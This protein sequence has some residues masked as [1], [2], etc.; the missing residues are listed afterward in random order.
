MKK[1][2]FLLLLVSGPW[3]MA[4]RYSI[5]GQVIDS[6]NGAMPSATILLQNAQD[7]TLANFAISNAQGQFEIKNVGKG[8]F[9]LKITF[10]G[11]KSETRKVVAPTEGNVLDFG[12]V[13][14]SPQSK[15]LSEV[16]VAGERIPI[17]VKKDTIEY[18]AAAFKTQANAVVE[19]MLKKMP[20]IEVET[21]GTITA[22]GEEVQR[23][24]VDGKEFFGRD[25]KLATQ[26][27]PADAVD[28]VQ[29]FDR[30]SEQAQFSGIDDGQREKTINLELKEDRKNGAFGNTSVGGGT[31]ERWQAKTN[32]NRFSPNSRL[33]FLGMANNVNQQGF[34]IDEYMNFT[35]G[36]Q[37]M[38]R[39]A[40]GGG[41]SVRMEFSSNNSTG[42]PLSFGG[43]NN[44]LMT[45]YAAGLNLN[46]N[47]G[48]KTELNSSYFFN[49]LDH[50]ITQSLIRENYL[51]NDLTLNYN[52]NSTQANTNLNHRANLTL[53]QEIDSA[54]SLRL[55]ANAS[56][57]QTQSLQ[58]TQSEN[59]SPN[60]TPLNDNTQTTYSE[61]G[62]YNWNSSL[63]YRHK[64]K[65]K[66]RTLSINADLDLSDNDRDGTL[67]GT[68]NNYGETT[69]TTITNQQNEQKTATQTY[70]GS[71]SFTE[72]LGGRKYLEA[73]YTLRQNNNKVD[74][75]VYDEVGEDLV[76]NDS[77]S[78]QYNSRYLYQR[79]GLNFRLNRTNYNFTV[80]AALQ[81]SNLK[82]N[83]ETLNA[84]ID[85]TFKNILPLAR[86]A[87]EFSTYRRMSF[88]YETS[89]QEPSIQQLQPV[90]D[91]SDLLNIYIG[92][93]DLRPSYRNSWRL[94][95]NTFN[96]SSSIGFFAFI[97]TDYTLNAIVNSQSTDENF[98]RT[99]IPVNAG[100]TFSV[101]GNANLTF[102]IRKMSSRLSIGSNVS[103]SESINLLNEVS[104]S[105]TQRTLSGNVRYNYRFKE[106]F[107]TN[108][109]ANLSHQGTTYEFNQPD[110]R[111]LN[112]T[113]RAEGNV[114]FLKNYQAT[115]DYAY[116]IYN[117]TTSDF[118]QE[119]PLLDM[120]VS[121]LFLKNNSGE[122]KFSVSNLLNKNLGVSQ[123]ASSN[124]LE[125]Q[126]SNSLGQY[127]ML[128][129]T[130]ALN[131]HLNPTAGGRR[132]GGMRMIMTQ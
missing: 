24:L 10:V 40:A 67:S 7:S 25:P 9:I 62:G 28:K 54:N 84:T 120:S 1:I 129:F 5:K 65:K 98:V 26:N 80:G 117:S 122:L 13:K 61:G 55:T 56:Y 34:S 71:L 74:R 82:G 86:F 66:S 124:Y 43:R 79:G 76:F 46:Q 41:G 114:S 36:S 63:L 95:Y 123:T 116:L 20:G 51:P 118:T 128:T 113:Y 27:L 21:D 131:K 115:I 70:G 42:V 69:E 52:Q 83:L 12:V 2:L 93:P 11:F 132:G 97:N 109:S 22:Q 19:D 75:L 3:A 119:I 107:E 105:I 64:F 130:Y 112:Q 100:E 108:L 111:F 85:N 15:E 99:T 103:Q 16:T 121:R 49:Q 78:N 126:V 57:N 29:V 127:Y 45:N 48:K 6:D 110:Q 35:G 58:N 94:S 68:L 53:D 50:D 37:Q 8:D 60:G 14:L 59:L 88:D 23:V 102:P 125:R 77:L 32:I 87:Y 106:I 72:P 4:Q 104:S 96:P 47:F 39:G 81:I 90:V 73:N 18:N 91:N 92:N 38:M 101:R 31:D 44:G 89:V 30:K 33:S 17:V